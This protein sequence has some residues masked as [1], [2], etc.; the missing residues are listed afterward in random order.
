V[1]F[2]LS[3]S[4]PRACRVHTLMS[5]LCNACREHRRTYVCSRPAYVEHFEGP[6]QRLRGR[7]CWKVKVQDVMNAQRLK[8]QYNRS[9]VRSL[10]FWRRS[11][12]ASPAA[13]SAPCRGT[14]TAKCACDGACSV[15]GRS[16]SVRQ[17]LECTLWAQPVAL[18][19]PDPA[20]P[21]CTLDGAG[22]RH[23]RNLPT[24]TESV[25]GRK[26]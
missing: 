26:S 14:K 11:H 20:S 5:A 10:H 13:T 7:R 24:S 12:S 15:A 21:P 18:P 3:S 8:L 25:T 9:E 17:R 1:R 19:W 16:G 4:A 6:G 23:R 22:S 2:A